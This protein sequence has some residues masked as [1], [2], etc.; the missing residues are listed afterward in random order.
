MSIN[1]SCETDEEPGIE[2]YEEVI[3]TV[4]NKALDKINCPYETEVNVVL[5]DDDRIME[6]N[7]EFY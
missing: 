5:T 7:D 3:E 6:I 4:I 1:I 2:N